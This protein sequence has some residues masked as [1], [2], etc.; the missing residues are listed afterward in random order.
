MSFK[1]HQSGRTGASTGMNGLALKCALACI[2]AAAAAMSVSATSYAASYQVAFCSDPATGLGVGV[3]PN[4]TASADATGW[5]FIRTGGVNAPTASATCPAAGVA[6]TLSNRIRV[7]G[8]SSA[9]TG[10]NGELR[11]TA[12]AGTQISSYELYRQVA[13]PTGWVYSLGVGGTFRENCNSFGCLSSWFM[14]AFGGP[15]LG[16]AG[17]PFDSSAPPTGKRVIDTFSGMSLAS[18][19]GCNTAPCAAG[20]ATD[21][22]GG[23]ISLDDVTMPVPA[24]ISGS[25]AASRP[26]HQTETVRFSATDTG[27]GVY[28]AVV[29]SDGSPVSAT[30]VDS[31]A[32]KC[33]DVR[34]GG[35]GAFEFAYPQPCPLAVVDREVSLDFSA[36][37]DGTHTISVR[38][39][40]G[41]GNESILYPAT[42]RTVEKDFSISFPDLIVGTP[43]EAATFSPT[44][45]HAA[46]VTFSIEG[47][48]PL[49]QGFSL[50][51]TT[52]VISG[53]P[54]YSMI[55]TPYRL[56]MQSLADPDRS[57]TKDFTFELRNDDGSPVDPTP[58]P[59]VR[60][61]QPGGRVTPLP[62]GAEPVLTTAAKAPAS[63]GAKRLTSSASTRIGRSRIRLS[64]PKSGVV[65]AGDADLRL[66]VT[67]RGVKAVRFY[68]DGT[69]VATDTRGRAFGFSSRKA[70]AKLLAAC[71][72]V[73]VATAS[74]QTKGGTRSLSLRLSVAKPKKKKSKSKKKRTKS[75][76]V[77]AFEAPSELVQRLNGSSS[78]WWLHNDGSRQDAI[79]D[80]DIDYPEATQILA[81]LQNPPTVAVID[82]GLD[83]KATIFNGRVVPGC[84]H[85]EGGQGLKDGCA[86]TDS[87]HGTHV[88][89]VIAQ[90]VPGIRILMCARGQGGETAC[91]R[92]ILARK[93]ELGIVALGMSY[94]AYRSLSSSEN[95]LYSRL[96]DE[97]IVPIASTG[98]DG[99]AEPHLPSGSP[100]VLAV[101]ASTDDDTVWMQSNF[102]KVD[103]VAPSVGTGIYLPDG[104]FV[105]QDGAT[106]LST[107]VVAAVVAAAAWRYPNLRGRALRDH[108]LARVDKVSESGGKAG[109]GRVN[110]CRAVS[111]QPDTDCPLDRRFRP[112]VKLDASA[113]TEVG[114]AETLDASASFTRNNPRQFTS[115]KWILGSKLQIETSTPKLN[116]R[117]SQA[118]QKNFRVVATDKTGAAGEGTTTIR[119]AKPKKS[120]RSRAWQ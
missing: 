28:R 100:N 7:S 38:L 15:P 26:V 65:S 58:L 85:F 116:T 73:Y 50:D 120:R 69:Q 76:S 72:S 68:L 90:A 61:Q 70:K 118:G 117:F 103:L 6:P 83:P 27:S 10:D 40:D 86:E 37:P 84:K 41:A 57:V 93:A 88:A 79:R 34:P 9:A 19:L 48:Y 115:F 89:S 55:P 104:S 20:A 44:A 113:R 16:T 81:P 94:G 12:P 45:A 11:F 82:S 71:P 23:R 63:C 24:A 17:G 114:E 5:Q 98:N 47:L 101:G 119:V 80:A 74:I 35:G 32:G 22:F 54:V 30:V 1:A 99:S 109:A 8:N 4:V 67:G 87:H 112:V 36:V 62:E 56:K 105:S 75:S 53:T 77:T 52:G 25:I 91:M 42:A 95:A 49:P 18:G 46:P 59:V 110:L 29:Y 64:G 92:E 2:V 13:V 31:N 107:P 3:Q 21:I 51:P 106:S 96:L 39:Q 66:K 108:V 43:G 78:N 102:G 111:D 97:G 14:G 33:A 60:E